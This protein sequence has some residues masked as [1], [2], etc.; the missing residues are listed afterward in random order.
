EALDA[1]AQ[2][3][4]RLAAIVALA[5]ERAVLRLD[6]AQLLLGAQVDG[7]DVLAAAAQ[8]L[9]LVL[10]V[11]D[12]G[13]RRARLDLGHGGDLGRLDLQHLADLV[14][15]VGEPALGA[16]VA[17]LGARRLLAR[18]AHRS[19]RRRRRLVGLGGRVLAVAE[20]VRG[21]AAA[22]LRR[23]D[24]GDQRA[25]LLLE[26]LRRLGKA[27]PLAAGLAEAGLER[28]DLRRCALAALAPGGAFRADRR[29][30]ALRQLDLARE[31]LRLRAPPGEVRALVGQPRAPPPRPG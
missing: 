20:L 29:E 15:D 14:A 3:L 23:F 26:R 17:L 5:G 4:D 1:R 31:R 22:G 10:D 18:A 24:L 13:Q 28:L 25:P 11:H 8:L 30:P 19:G 7:A 12:V 6:L 21:G 2:P 27:R 16:L 9:Q